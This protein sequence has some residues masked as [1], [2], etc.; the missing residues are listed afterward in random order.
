MSA[1][2]LTPSTKPRTPKAIRGIVWFVRD[3]ASRHRHPANRMAHVVG[4]PLAPFGTLY[5]LFAG[6]FV[7]A[8]AAFA[9]GYL[10]QWAGHQAEG[11]EV[12]E[13][14]LVKHIAGRLR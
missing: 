3:Y 7:P 4:V 5:L 12:G 14:I 13:W 2:P 11:N 8:A 9:G 6:R 10:L 1:A